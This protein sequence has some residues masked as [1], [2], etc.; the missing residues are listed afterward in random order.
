MADMKGGGDLE[1]SADNIFLL[2]RPSL[3]PELS[4]QEYEVVKNE[5]MVGIDKAR[6]GSKIKEVK[7]VFDNKTN[8]YLLP[9]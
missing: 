8:R 9:Q 2:W 5:L 7:L 3:N 1:A 6:R 4:P